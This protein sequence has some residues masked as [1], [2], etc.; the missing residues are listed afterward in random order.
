MLQLAFKENV[1]QGFSTQHSGWKTWELVHM[2][3]VAEVEKPGLD[4]FFSLHQPF[5][6]SLVGRKSLSSHTTLSEEFNHG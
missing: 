4:G 5:E 6:K 2:F 3:K 1:D